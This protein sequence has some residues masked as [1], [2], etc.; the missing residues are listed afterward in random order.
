MKYLF[1]MMDNET[2][3]W[4]AQEVSGGKESYDARR[5]FAKARGLMGKKPMT[6]ITD[7][8]QGY[9]EAHKKEF[10]TK[11][12][13]ERNTCATSRSKVTGTTTGWND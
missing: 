10:W 2:R 1:A 3:F 7:G 12:N 8:L 13:R 5:L 9:M 4:I 11:R 6:I